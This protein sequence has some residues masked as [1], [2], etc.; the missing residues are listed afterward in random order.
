M[1]VFDKEFE[2][3]IQRAKSKK[4]PVRVVIAGADLENILEGAFAAEAHGICKPVLVGDENKIRQID[5]RDFSGETIYAGK[6]FPDPVS[7][8]EKD[9]NTYDIMVVGGDTEKIVVNLSEFTNKGIVDYTVMLDLKDNMKA[10]ILWSS[11]E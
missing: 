5:I 11:E 8:L 7:G 4:N 6:L 3:L 2:F 10:T 1:Y 9:P